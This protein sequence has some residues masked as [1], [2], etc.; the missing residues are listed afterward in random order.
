MC[1]CYLA[2]EAAYK[3]DEPD[4]GADVPPLHLDQTWLAFSLGQ[5]GTF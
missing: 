2:A 3:E 4:F 1:I 5:E